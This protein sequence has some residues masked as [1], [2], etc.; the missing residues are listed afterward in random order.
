MFAAAG[1][2]DLPVKGKIQKRWFRYGVVM[3][4]MG[5]AGLVYSCGQHKETALEWQE[6]DETALSR[7]DAGSEFF[8]Q[9][10]ERADAS[11]SGQETVP[12]LAEE[13]HSRAAPVWVY[14][15]GAVQSPGVYQLSAEDRICDAVDAAGGFSEDADQCAVNLAEL[16]TDGSQ[17][18]I[19]QI[20]ESAAVGSNE[21]GEA[22]LP[23]LVNINTATKSQLMELPGIGAAKAEAILSYRE[24][25]G[26]F[27]CIEDIMQ[28]SGIKEASFAQIK[29]LITV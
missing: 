15:C 24:S 12:I 16:L 7:V 8:Q 14:V 25:V 2:E 20:G 1:K 17:I 3:L 18:Y 4:L 13:T 23:G 28:V 19:P 26:R 29:S 27:S 11:L 22:H 21:A 5:L 6:T 10:Q 9:G